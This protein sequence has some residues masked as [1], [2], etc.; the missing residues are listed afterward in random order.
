MKVLTLG[1]GFVADHLPY[2]KTTER[3]SLSKGY[4]ISVLENYK[5]DVV[6]NC[7]GKT[8]RPNVD[9]CE[10][11][12]IETV[13]GNVTLP[14]LIA[15]AC[16][17]LGIHMIQVGSGCIYFGPSPYK[18]HTSYAVDPGWKETDFANPASF[19]SKTKY[20]CD[21]MLAPMPHVTTLRIRMPVSDKD[22]PRNLINKLRGYKQVI[23]IPN[24]MTLMSDLTRCI[25]WVATNR[26]GGIFHVANPQPLTAARIMQEYQKYVPEHQF[27]IITEGQLD[28]MT[29]AKRSNCILNTDKLRAAGFKMS[30]TEEALERTMAE[31]V[32][33]MRRNNV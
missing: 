33:D 27:E 3:F 6:V 13:S 1:S 5:P 14:L 24:S 29:V 18:G 2:Q 25:D 31:Y 11:H 30:D 28:Q 9:W 7:L 21:L 16:A 4:I 20:S 32:K 22:V 19:Y 23:D 15:E 17:D 10:S 26:P 8:G 12:K